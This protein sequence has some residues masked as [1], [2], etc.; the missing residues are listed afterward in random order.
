MRGTRSTAAPRGDPPSPALLE[1]HH[2][3]L[4]RQSGGTRLPTVAA[5]VSLTR[6]D[7]VMCVGDVVVWCADA[8][9]TPRLALCVS[10]PSALTG[11]AHVIVR[12]LNP[13]RL[14]KLRGRHWTNAIPP[15]VADWQLG[16]S[17]SDSDDEDDDDDN[18]HG[19]GAID[20][21]G[22]DFDDDPLDDDGAGGSDDEDGGSD[23]DGGGGGGTRAQPEPLDRPRGAGNAPAAPAAA[24]SAPAAARPKTSMVGYR[25]LR[26]TMTRKQV[27]TSDGAIAIANAAVLAGNEQREEASVAGAVTSAPQPRDLACGVNMH[28]KFTFAPEDLVCKSLL[29]ERKPGKKKNTLVA[30]ALV[31]A[32]V[33]RDGAIVPPTATHEEALSHVAGSDSC[34][35]N[36]RRRVVNS[37]NG[38]VYHSPTVKALRAGSRASGRALGLGGARAGL[39][40]EG[41]LLVLGRQEPFMAALTGRDAGTLKPLTD[42]TLADLADWADMGRK[43]TR[44]EV[45]GL[46][47]GG[48]FRF[49]AAN[50]DWAL[51]IHCTHAC[52]AAF[53]N[54]QG[55][56]P[57]KWLG[58]LL[59]MLTGK[60]PSA[61]QRGEVNGAS[62]GSGLDAYLAARAAA[63]GAW[64]GEKGGGG[65][66]GDGRGRACAEL[67]V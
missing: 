66:G 38:G 42:D 61:A 24:P 48:V 10:P 19:W 50:G 56:V 13:E 58:R 53:R 45:F 57:M 17:D 34:P 60:A 14:Q 52:T 27:A 31:M 33:L 12:H 41:I 55:V 51:L 32:D 30:S 46:D 23:N 15:G 54:R 26:M 28:V 8:A 39:P 18:E 3:E 2:Q 47:D 20:N 63:G 9:V 22:D 5:L 65:G 35:A 4:R 43:L 37:P 67:V 7:A 62:N 64:R 21:D 59:A 49:T 11:I 25:G 6:D 16:G 40:H 44:K 36:S 29:W 1:E